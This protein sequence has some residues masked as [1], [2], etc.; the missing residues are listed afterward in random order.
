MLYIQMHYKSCFYVMFLLREGHLNLLVSS[1]FSTSFT[2]T[3]A[4]ILFSFR[5]RQHYLPLAC[6]DI[7]GYIAGQHHR[8]PQS[9]H[10]TYIGALHLLQNK[11][12]NCSTCHTSKTTGE[13]SCT[14]NYTKDK[15]NVGTLGTAVKELFCSLMY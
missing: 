3:N 5:N 8:L 10:C 9:S 2:D 6:R 14:A 4:Q 7:L 1:R 12:Q 13:Y 15:Q 11:L